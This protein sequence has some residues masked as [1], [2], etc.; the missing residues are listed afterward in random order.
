MSERLYPGGLAV[1]TRSVM[2]GLR[3]AGIPHSVLTSTVPGLGVM[4]PEELASVQ[5]VGGLFWGVWRPFIFRKLVAWTREQEPFIIH[6]LSALTTPVCARLAQALELPFIITV[7]HF[8]KRGGL[9]VEKRCHGFVAVSESLRENLVNDA[10]I[11][12]ELVR[13]IPAGIRVPA[14]LGPRP[15]AYSQGNSVPLVSSFGKLIARKDFRTFLQASRL[16]VDR[17]GNDV[18]FIISGEGP[19]ESALRKLTREL[20]IDKQVTFC[21]GTAA[22]DKLLHDTDV[23]VQSSRSEGFGTMVLQAMA[24][25]VPVVAT[26]TGGIIALVKHGETGFLV[27]VGEAEALATRVLNLLTDIELCRKMGESARLYAARNFDLG[28]MM[29]STLDLYADAIATTATRTMA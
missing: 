27:P 28:Q 6:G 8:Q 29:A 2:G 16:I 11:P 25:G 7:H 12:K 23:Y 4:T 1:Y 10:Q 20:K 3:E 26:S 5:V 22:H 24:H 17:L 21:H 9:R 19:D 18:S 13:V 15:A 14:E